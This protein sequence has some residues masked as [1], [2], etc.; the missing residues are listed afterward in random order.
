MLKQNSLKVEN[1]WKKSASKKFSLATFFARRYEQNNHSPFYPDLRSD[2]YNRF[3]KL[4]SLPELLFFFSLTYQ[5]KTV[6]RNSETNQ[7]LLRQ[8][9]TS[10]LTSFYSYNASK[11]RKNNLKSNN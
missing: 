3:F 9:K 8:K 6:G 4:Y 7:S 5:N 10:R 2:L 11:Q 1:D